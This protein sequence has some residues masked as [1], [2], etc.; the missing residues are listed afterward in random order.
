MN[1]WDIFTLPF[2]A[3]RRRQAGAGKILFS[4]V[5]RMGRCMSMKSNMAKAIKK[6]KTK[7]GQ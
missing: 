3:M 1:F 5:K 2:N 6:D 7:T 4:P